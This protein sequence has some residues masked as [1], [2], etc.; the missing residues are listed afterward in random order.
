M[1]LH[2]FPYFYFTADKPIM[3]NIGYLFMGYD[4]ISGNPMP[5]E[6]I[7]DPGF[8]EK[9]FKASYAHERETDD[10][11]Y[12]I[13][14][15][16]DL[17][18]EVACQIDFTSETIE[19]EKEYQKDLLAHVA[20]SATGSYGV[21]TGSFSASTDYS[22]MSNKFQSNSNVLVKSEA[23]CLIYKAFIQSNNPPRLTRNF[24]RAVKRLA[25]GSLGCVAF[26]ESFG[27]HY[28]KQVDFG[29]RYAKVQEISKSKKED[30]DEEGIDINVAA[31]VSVGQSYGAEVEVGL[32]TSKKNRESY[33]EAVEST[34]E[35]S[36]GSVP[37]SDGTFILLIPCVP[38]K[39]TILH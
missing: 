27:T 4:I 33:S 26:F 1:Y 12:T 9:I 28:L 34:T 23:V 17:N 32:K 14:D 16:I 29:S 39:C 38:K 2:N 22:K 19:T 18:S 37:P 10:R 35:V 7:V 5:T 24:K 21:V 6:S 13:P 36:I 20:V 3:P 11:R 31:S 30:L 15:H 8:R 25:A